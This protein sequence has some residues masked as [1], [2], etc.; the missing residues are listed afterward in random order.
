MPL[1]TS[2]YYPE[3]LLP[4]DPDDGEKESDSV[5]VGE[6]P[7]EV[8]THRPGDKDVSPYAPVDIAATAV[9]WVLV[10]MMMPVYGIMLVF[11]LSLL[12]FTPWPN[13]VVFTLVVAA[14]N[15]LLPALLILILKKM[16]I[17]HDIGLNERRERLIP[18]I[19]VALCMGA[20]AFFM[21]YKNAP[22]WVVSFFTGGVAA[23]VVNMIVNR[24]W[25]ISAH[26]AGIAGI[27][28]L[29]LRIQA[30]GY[31]Q[32]NLLPW[33]VTAIALAGLMG[34]A[35]VWLGRHTVAQ[36]LAGYAVGFLGVYFL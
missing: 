24:W 25:K 4:P 16:G 21:Y 6:Q 2:S 14:F 31:P 11:G 30:E 19:I 12:T 17:V 27:V 9:S 1:D 28:A 3:P 36:V 20:T 15:V 34:S 8:V 33:I 18:Y 32:S 26:A 5:S 35:R 22:V 10:P 23:G 13:K 7:E 29:L